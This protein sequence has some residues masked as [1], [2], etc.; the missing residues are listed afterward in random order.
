MW[1]TKKVDLFAGGLSVSSDPCRVPSRV[2]LTHLRDVSQGH[3]L[4]FKL[5]RTTTARKVSFG[6]A[7]RCRRVRRLQV[8]W[9]RLCLLR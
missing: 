9:L 8:S 3:T 6:H 2:L 4:D 5:T 7:E 1:H